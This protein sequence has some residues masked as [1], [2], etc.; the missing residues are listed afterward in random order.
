M[1]REP[2]QAFFS[3]L[4]LISVSKLHKIGA[5]CYCEVVG[6]ENS[7]TQWKTFSF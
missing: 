4:F 1:G 6:I 3:I 7:A 5:S 2:M